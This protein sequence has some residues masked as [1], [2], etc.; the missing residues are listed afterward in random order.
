MDSFKKELIFTG[1]STESYLYA[2][3]QFLDG[4]NGMTIGCK[5]LVVDFSDDLF[6]LNDDNGLPITLSKGDFMS[7]EQWRDKKIDLINE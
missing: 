7:V 1:S 2:Y 6:I 5:Y 3:L 4:K